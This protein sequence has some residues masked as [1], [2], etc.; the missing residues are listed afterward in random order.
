MN[1]WLKIA[2]LAAMGLA[3]GLLYGWVLAPVQYVDVSPDTLRQDYK[4]DYVIMV[5]EIY[6][7]E[8]DID[9]AAARLATLGT[10]PPEEQVAAALDYAL[11]HEASSADIARLVALQKAISAWALQQGQTP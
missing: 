5:A 3:A 4:S 10:Q 11:A 8:A 2:L 6:Q 7:T 1:R 9:R